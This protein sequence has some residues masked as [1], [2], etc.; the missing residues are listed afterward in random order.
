MRDLILLQLSQSLHYAPHYRA[1]FFKFEV[2]LSMH[3][4]FQKIASFQH[5]QNHIVAVIGLEDSLQF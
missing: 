2:G 1:N 5:L 4:V 3:E